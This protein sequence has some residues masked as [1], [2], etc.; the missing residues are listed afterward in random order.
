MGSGDKSW[1]IAGGSQIIN[2]R[3]HVSVPGLTPQS[4]STDWS[5][6]PGQPRR[7]QI[8]AIAN[9]SEEICPSYVLIIF[10]SFLS[11]ITPIGGGSYNNSENRHLFPGRAPSNR[12]PP[13]WSSQLL[14]LYWEMDTESERPRRWFWE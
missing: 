3:V 6:I 8:A 9:Q 11:L 2:G 7:F 10:P 1:I 13:A 14:T 4:G 12:E 5:V